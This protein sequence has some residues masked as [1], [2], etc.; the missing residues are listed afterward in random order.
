MAVIAEP[1]PRRR[2]IRGTR[3]LDV[4]KQSIERRV[5]AELPYKVQKLAI[6]LAGPILLSKPKKL[7]EC[8]LRDLIVK[9]AGLFPVCITGPEF[10]VR[11]QN[12]PFLKSFMPASFSNVLHIKAS[13]WERKC[14]KE[15]TT[16]CSHT[17][18]SLPTGIR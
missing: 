16:P 2:N 18:P 3:H 13:L 11:D 9:E 14:L 15:R 7:I 6:S 12:Q 5:K 8:L 4:D 17:A 10:N 1:P